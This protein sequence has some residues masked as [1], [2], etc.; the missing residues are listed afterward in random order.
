MSSGTIPIQT[1]D[2]E[3]GCDE[4]M[5]DHYETGVSNWRDLLA[6][7]SFNPYGPLDSAF[8]PNHTAEVTR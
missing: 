2:A 8:C 3:E 6:G 5:V 1:C 7:W 4:W